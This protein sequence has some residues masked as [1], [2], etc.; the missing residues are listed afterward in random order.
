M[1]IVA[2]HGFTEP[3]DSHTPA[4]FGSRELAKTYAN[5]G[6]IGKFTLIF[7]RPLV[8]DTP[9]KVERAWR[10]SDALDVEGD[11][12]PNVMRALEDWARDQNYDG[13][14][15]DD[16]AFEGELG[17]EWAVGTFGDPQIVALYPER[18]VVPINADEAIEGM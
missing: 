15:V 2:Y 16:G 4:Y 9:E 8:L 13:I 7:K 18:Q 1:N 14:I 12:F 17:Y 5:G 6:R 10:E 3:N 11:F